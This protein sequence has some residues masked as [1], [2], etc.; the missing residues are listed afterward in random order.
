[1]RLVSAPIVRAFRGIDFKSSDI[2]M[3]SICH[4]LPIFSINYPLNNI[5]GMQKI[6]FKLK[7]ILDINVRVNYSNSLL[8]KD[9]KKY[10]FF[11]KIL[12]PF[13]KS[14]ERLIIFFF[15]SKEYDEIVKNFNE[16]N[17]FTFC[18]ITEIFLYSSALRLGKKINFTP[19]GWDT[20]S[21]FY[22]P[23]KCNSYEIWGRVDEKFLLNKLP[24]AQVK[25]IATPFSQFKKNT[26]RQNILMYEGTSG[27]VPKSY[28]LRVI[29]EILSFTRESQ[30]GLMVKKL[31]PRLSCFKDDELIN[32]GCDIF[33]STSNFSDTGRVYL[34][35]SNDLEKLIPETV[36]FVGFN[37][38]HGYLEF[39]LNLIPSVG[40][41]TIDNY[42][43][44][45][46]VETLK[47][48]GVIFSLNSD[49][50]FS[51]LFD[52]AQESNLN[53]DA[54]TTRMEPKNGIY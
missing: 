30:Y 24:N 26:I 27:E 29:N 40:Y 43:N 10:Y 46:I 37:S 49:E 22:V 32:M 21:V 7:K 33:Q 34:K 1:M 51:G 35:E 38:T 31:D 3:T 53:F 19:D 23:T 5:N 14:L 11:S 39:G 20:Y 48:S 9:N 44:S 42:Q 15:N 12:N 41:I 45:L 36:L 4:N 52:R 50:K 54:F 17:I 2:Y 28:Q 25:K 6:L 18:F 8:R 16:V 13:S 47:N